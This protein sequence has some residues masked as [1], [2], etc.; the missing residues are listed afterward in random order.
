MV[1][2]TGDRGL[3]GGSIQGVCGGLGVVVWYGTIGDWMGFIC[4]IPLTDWQNFANII[5]K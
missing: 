5:F 3:W 2:G 1:L 4:A